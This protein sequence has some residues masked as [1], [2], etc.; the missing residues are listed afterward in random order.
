MSQICMM[1]HT[2]AFAVDSF[3]ELASPFVRQ[4][5]ILYL[6]AELLPPSEN[7]KILIVIYIEDRLV[8]KFFFFVKLYG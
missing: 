1:V 5:K 4:L 3:L 8:V 2:K 7:L 6:Q